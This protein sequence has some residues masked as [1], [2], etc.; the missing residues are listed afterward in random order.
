[1]TTP[2]L[3]AICA[4]IL[5]V[6]HSASAD[7]TNQAKALAHF[8]SQWDWK[9]SQDA[10]LKANKDAQGNELPGSDKTLGYLLYPA[11]KNAS[12]DH[13]GEAHGFLNGDKVLVRCLVDEQVLKDAGGGKGYAANLSKTLGQ[14]ADL[15]V[16]DELK[17]GGLEA[18][19]HWHDAGAD[20]DVT[21]MV[22]QDKVLVEVA[23]VALRKK[24]Q[25]KQGTK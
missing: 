10:F 9:Q 11:D 18:L 12:T 20:H 17:K 16:T 3:A 6:S 5:A 13:D 8:A 4:V 7:D 24:L 1:L 19:Y 25:E 23:D 21:L 22:Y 14:A 2:L 15:D